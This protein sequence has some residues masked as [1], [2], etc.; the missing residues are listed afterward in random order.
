[1]LYFS[2]A[3]CLFFLP[4]ATTL[5]FVTAHY[6]GSRKALIW[7]LVCSFFF[8][9]YWDIRFLPLLGFSILF[10]LLVGKKLTI[11]SSRSLLIFGLVVNLLLIGVFKYANFAISMLQ[12]FGFTVKDLSIPL[13]IGISFFTFQQIAFLV[14]SY[15][16]GEED[17]DPVRY[18]LFISLYCQLVSGPIIHQKDIIPQLM[19]K[20]IYRFNS[21]NTS[22]GIYLFAIGLSK[23]LLADLFTDWSTIS[24]SP[25][26][27]MTFFGSWMSA[28]SY[29]VR[30]YFD[31][32]GYIDMARASGLLLN[33][34]VPIN[35]DTPYSA[36]NFSDFWNR[37]NITLSSF[38]RTY[39]YIPLGGNRQGFVRTQLNLILTMFL[40]GLWHGDGWCFILWGLIHGVYLIINHCTRH[41]GIKT[42]K[43]L[44]WAFTLLGAV[45]AWVFFKAESVNEAIAG[46]KAMLG[47]N[48]LRIPLPNSILSSD[49]L[50]WMI[51][52]LR[53]YHIIDSFWNMYPIVGYHGIVQVLCT[54]AAIVVSIVG[55]NSNKLAEDFRP[56]WG[57]L[58]FTIAV[59]AVALLFMTNAKAFIYFQ[60]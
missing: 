26:M 1:M 27:E 21:I 20:G 23:K 49:K 18:S 36:I 8:Y 14:E 7:L 56:T 16:T 48:G 37:W 45:F 41:F 39:L 2:H 4:V 17:V 32:S 25:G 33:I 9:G 29:A 53:E 40:T 54:A 43:P 30:I 11:S 58:L 35:F 50:S 38:F 60:F 44:A 24:Y 31:F 51:Y 12:D 3:Y 13:P 42:P 57:R 28:F 55:P 47:F 19:D 10:N 34:K 5:F 59:F 46:A 52:P 15:R 22:A 6:M